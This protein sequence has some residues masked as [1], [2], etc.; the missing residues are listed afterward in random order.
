MPM[1][2]QLLL[3]SL[4]S[5]VFGQLPDV[6][7][8]GTDALGM[9]GV[10]SGILLLVLGLIAA[11][12]GLRLFRPALFIVGFVMFSVLG[13]TILSQPVLQISDTVIVAG[14]LGIGLVGGFIAYAL[15]KLGLLVLGGVGGISLAFFLL[16]WQGNVL[17]ISETGRTV[18]IVFC[19]LVGAILIHFL[20]KPA[21]IIFTSILGS[22][23]FCNGVDV[24]AK[25]GFNAST[26]ALLNGD[27]KTSSLL[28]VS[29]PKL[30]AVL[31]CVPVMAMIGMSVQFYSIREVK[32]RKHVV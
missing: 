9:S 7:S 31:A 8:A 23:V 26:K 11:F 14:S 24:F 32:N 22:Y 13:Y 4:F 15:V 3:L 12:F 5:A 25:V 1:A 19:A 16:S 18:F 6:S 27:I 2:C 20:E 28:L 17:A 29:N 10:V 21:I 30:Y